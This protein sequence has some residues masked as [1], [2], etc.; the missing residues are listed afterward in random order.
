MGPNNLFELVKIRIFGSSNQQ[1]LTVV[2]NIWET[3]IYGDMSFAVK[4][5]TG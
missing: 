2:K 1:V 5:L 4:D 3:K